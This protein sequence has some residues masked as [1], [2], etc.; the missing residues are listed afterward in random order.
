MAES[1]SRL[2]IAE[3]RDRVREGNVSAVIHAQ[4]EDLRRKH[5]AN[6]NPFWEVKL[7]DEGDS[8]VLRSWQDTRSFE[9]C[10]TLQVGA[11]VCVS[12]EFARHPSFG[13]DAKRWELRL[14]GDAERAALFEG[15]RLASVRAWEFIVE[16]VGALRDPRLR[17]LGVRYLD[18]FGDRFRRAAAARQNHH[19]WRGGLVEHTAQMMRSAKALCTVYTDWNEDLLVSGVL[20]HDCGKLW[21]TCPPEEGFGIPFSV[22][23]ELL[24]HIAIGFEFVSSLWR[25]LPLELWE[26]LTPSNDSVRA[27]LLHLIGSHHGQHEFGSPVLPKTPEAFALHFIDNLD[28]KLE[29]VRAAYEKASPVAPGIFER[30]WP[31]TTNLVAPLPA[32]TPP[33]PVAS[34]SDLPPS[35]AAD[36]DELVS[37]S[38]DASAD[39]DP[40]SLF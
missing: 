18:A 2:K 11:A 17:E 35:L 29:T 25:E 6:G 9:A 20:F 23:G 1:V 14:L 30:A 24:G 21:E 7:R 8:L 22:E 32:V 31:L 5:A 3:L 19:A 27:H 16:S 28:A 34:E 36:P 4:V 33:D 13:L 37:G 12:G 39:K 26:D 38:V 10:E 15:E 40:Y